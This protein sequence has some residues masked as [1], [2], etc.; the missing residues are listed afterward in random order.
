MVFNANASV[1]SRSRKSV[2]KK[3][4]KSNRGSTN[5]LECTEENSRESNFRKFMFSRFA[6]VFL[7][8]CLYMFLENGNVYNN[9]TVSE[10][11]WGSVNA[12]KLAEANLRGEQGENDEHMRKD[13][14][15]QD[16]A[17]LSQR[18]YGTGNTDDSVDSLQG[19]GDSSNAWDEHGNE[20]L[21]F[22]EQNWGSYYTNSYGNFPPAADNEP[23]AHSA[24]TLD[25]GT[26]RYGDSNAQETTMGSTPS[27]LGTTPNEY[28]FGGA[29]SV[30]YKEADGAVAGTLPG[31][32]NLNEGV[33]GSN[34]STGGSQGEQAADDKYAVFDRLYED[35]LGRT[36]GAS[37]LAG[38]GASGSTGSTTDAAATGGTWDD[39]LGSGSEGHLDGAAGTS[40]TGRWDGA[41]G[42]GASGRWDGAAGTSASG[43]WDGAAGTSATGR[44]DG[45]AGTSASGRWDGAAGT[46]ASGTSASGRWDGA[47]GTSA[48]GRWDGAAGTSASGRWNGAAG[49]GTTG[50]WDGAAGTGSSGRWHDGLGSDSGVRLGTGF[51]AP[52][53]A[54]RENIFNKPSDPYRQVES[55]A[56][57]DSMWSGF[58]DQYESFA[59]PKMSTSS[60]ST[61]DI[62]PGDIWAQYKQELENYSDAKEEL[63]NIKHERYSSERSSSRHH[64]HR[65]STCDRTSSGPRSKATSDNRVLKYNERKATSGDE[66]DRRRK[67]SKILEQATSKHIRGMIDKLGSTVNMRDMFYIFNSLI[68]H[69]RRKFVNM[70]ED[71]MLFWDKTAKSYGLPDYY[72]NRQWMKAF[73]GMT[74]ELFLTEKKLFDR[75]YQLLQNGFCART[76]FIQFLKETKYICGRMRKEIEDQW[77]EYLV[78]KVRGFW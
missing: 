33:F 60:G 34:G 32:S 70:E 52:T 19:G 13:F 47:A 36:E 71:T 49:T 38:V 28:S 10:R 40:T 73:D 20:S 23:D 17:N 64:E 46:S 67:E 78:S 59:E 16:M 12:R 30:G 66:Y 61:S 54:R 25:N 24:S 77:K 44:W 43:R 37:G 7:V 39:G 31:T 68:N 22:D 2:V 15:P 45:A 48:S 74:K 5:M 69:E 57:S 63:E 76:R 21:G 8:G 42:T 55:R 75:L 3:N 35:Y 65:R 1:L 18:N 29:P 6:K 9:N 51:G 14:E 72:K 11:H 26:F 58:Q 50:R 27:S 4:A 56:P 53:S 62:Y 41:A